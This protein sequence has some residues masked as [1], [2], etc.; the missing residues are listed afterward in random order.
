MLQQ[1]GIGHKQGRRVG[2]ASRRTT[3][4]SSVN[5]PPFSKRTGAICAHV[6]FKFGTLPLRERTGCDLAGQ[7]GLE[8]FC[9]ARK[10]AILIDSFAVPKILMVLVLLCTG[11]IVM[12]EEN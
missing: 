6:L 3:I 12:M 8:R 4:K 10:R 2:A 1:Y 9:A 7:N 11:T 5:A